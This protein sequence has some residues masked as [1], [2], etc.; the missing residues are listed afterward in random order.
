[1]LALDT[2]VRRRTGLEGRLV[3]FKG[4][5]ANP[6]QL[7]DTSGEDE[8]FSLRRLDGSSKV[9]IYVHRQNAINCRWYRIF[10][11]AVMR[12]FIQSDLENTYYGEMKKNKMICGESITTL[13]S[14]FIL[15]M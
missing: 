11:N 3:L 1:M 5:R 4:F 14:S 15:V 2:F 10:G 12:R 7:S 13:N 6:N 9:G 8:L